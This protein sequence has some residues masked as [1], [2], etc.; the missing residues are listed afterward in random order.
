MLS[1]QQFDRA[2]ATFATPGDFGVGN[3]ASCCCLESW[4]TASRPVVPLLPHR[5]RC[6]RPLKLQRY[7]PCIA[8]RGEGVRPDRLK[9]F[10]GLAD[11]A[12]CSRHRAPDTLRH[13]ALQR[14]L[15]LFCTLLTVLYLSSATPAAPVVPHAP[16]VCPCSAG[17]SRSGLGRWDRCCIGCSPSPCT[18][19]FLLGL[20]VHDGADQKDQTNPLL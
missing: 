13:F 20:R 7:E 6:Q 17:T 14:T 4:R 1:I 16:H 15:V 18:A 5:I 3:V 11:R 9:R 10:Q 19:D 12:R 2:R 8:G